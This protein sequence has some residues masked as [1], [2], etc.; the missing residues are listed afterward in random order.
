MLHTLSVSM[1]PTGTELSSVLLSAGTQQALS[2]DSGCDQRT[3]SFLPRKLK[4]IY[5]HQAFNTQA[6][7][8]RTS[9]C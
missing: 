4:V 7:Q 9:P 6:W 1:R 3:G 2:G 8:S 5:P